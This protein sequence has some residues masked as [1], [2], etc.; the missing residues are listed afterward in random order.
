MK[1]KTAISPAKGFFISLLSII[2][3]LSF[4]ACSNGDD[5]KS[6]NPPSSG[7]PTAGETGGSLPLA[8]TVNKPDGS[9]VVVTDTVN[10]ISITQAAEGTELILHFTPPT[11]TAEKAY[12]ID[13]IHITKD[14]D[15][16]AVEPGPKLEDSDGKNSCYKIL[17][18]DSAITITL[19]CKEVSYHKVN[20]ADFDTTKASQITGSVVGE[21]Y[22]AISKV[23]I[24]QKIKLAVKLAN[25]TVG[26][27][28]VSLKDSAGNDVTY[29]EDYSDSRYGCYY[30]CTFEMPDSDVNF[31]VTFKSVSLYE[32]ELRQADGCTMELNSTLTTYRAGV[33]VKVFVDIAVGYELNGLSA[34]DNVGNPVSVSKI[35]NPLS[36]PEYYECCYSFVMPESNVTLSSSC[37]QL[38]TCTITAVQPVNG[39]ISFTDAALNNPQ[40]LNSLG[41]PGSTITLYVYPN[42]DYEL[43]SFTVTDSDGGT[44]S[45]GK[46]EQA[47]GWTNHHYVVT[48][49]MPEKS[50]VVA[51]SFKQYVHNIFILP[52]IT[53]GTVT[54][55]AATA[56]AGD[57]ITLTLN[58]ASGYKVQI[59]AYDILYQAGPG[60]QCPVEVNLSEDQK[61]CTFEMPKGNVTVQ[62]IFVLNQ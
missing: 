34:V 31:A 25:Q 29:K 21:V 3:F 12:A 37:T 26:V 41:V 49:V 22:E 60:T 62:G 4:S 58:P 42:E 35:E 28:T 16:S 30:Y 5:D 47:V 8:I 38:T 45:F 52:D 40:N 33:E 51:A 46:T 43:D 10:Y 9:V 14:S 6:E 7:V 13:E 19:T 24:G 20:I 32:I 27:E 18:P 15:G 55:S 50:V 56:K 39:S 53:G 2:L 54:S 57:T 17:M 48:F 44:V 36:M 11:S 59:A 1:Y 23:R 61:S